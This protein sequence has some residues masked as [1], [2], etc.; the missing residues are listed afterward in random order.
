[1]SVT[2]LKCANCVT[3]RGE[4][5]RNTSFQPSRKGIRTIVIGVIVVLLL[6]SS[7]GTV[8]AGQLGVRTR[9]NAVVGSVNEGLYFKLPFIEKVHI[10]D[11]QTQKEQVSAEAASADLQ[12]VNTTVAVNYNIDS[13]KVLDLYTHVGVDYKIRVI[14]PAIQ[15]VVKAVT[16]NY[17]AEQLITKRPEVTEAI[18]AALAAR[19]SPSG[20]FV[21]AVSVVN[22]NFSV[23]FND[24]IEAKVTAEQN[25]LAAKNKLDQ[26][27]FEAEQRITTARAEAEAIKIQAEAIQSQ[28][29]AGYV[30]LKA[31]EKWDGKLPTQMIPA[32]SVPFV[33]LNR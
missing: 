31:I 9:F 27:K 26:I 33:N 18:Q 29:G 17:T 13:Q 19:L 14:D 7:V 25:A 10:V 22:F 16:A 12:T 8:S 21:T 23:S 5:L 15:E 24:A 6:T 1:M 11:I 4:F 28:G 30:D 32:G 20:I 2:L 3:R